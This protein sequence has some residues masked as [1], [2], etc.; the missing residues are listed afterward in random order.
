MEGDEAPMSEDD[1]STLGSPEFTGSPAI[2]ISRAASER[3]DLIR[4]FRRFDPIKLAATF[5]GLLTQPVLQSSC[6]RLEL[7]VHLSLAFASGPRAATSDLV[8]KGFASVGSVY[9]HYEDPAED[10]FV[11]NIS[12]PRGNYLVLEGTWE[13]GT[14]YLQR[15]VNLAA[16][17][18]DVAPLSGVTKSIHALLAVSHLMCLRVGLRRNALSTSTRLAAVPDD[19]IRVTSTLRHLVQFSFAELAAAGVDAADLRPFAFDFDRRA[20]LATQRILHSDLERRPLFIERDR[21]TLVLPTAVSSAIRRYFIERVGFGRNRPVLHRQLALEYSRELQRSP[22]L[23][24]ARG[25]GLPFFPSPWGAMC[26]SSM[27]VDKGRHLLLVFLLDGLNEFS[28]D[29]L[30]GLFRSTGE[31]RQE[32]EQAVKVMQDDCVGS[33][34]FRDGVVLFVLC[35]VGRGVALSP[36]SAREGW[37]VEYISAPD[38]CTLGWSKGMQT[39]RLWRLFQMRDEL[40][41]MGA[42]LQ[43]VNGL[44]NLVAWANSLDGHLVPHADVPDEASERSFVFMVRQN[45]LLDLR[46]DP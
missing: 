8:R 11:G 33:A 10:V 23:G 35:G 26:C 37:W 4:A 22:I 9:G 19:L 24:L 13:C 41:R 34:G 29:G 30:T 36:L 44:L 5:G 21:V 20:V 28:P 7:L 3:P 27:E 46:H 16:T 6:L 31:M 1:P 12:S 17:L 18:P 32:I 14:F 42:Y 43:N 15:F 2:E 25:H 38:F 40:R 45:A 39:L